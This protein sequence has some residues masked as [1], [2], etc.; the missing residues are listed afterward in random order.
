MTNTERLDLDSA[1]PAKRLAW[2]NSPDIRFSVPPVCTALWT[3]DDWCTYV[4]WTTENNARILA[5]YRP[6]IHYPYED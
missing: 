6:S 1:G 4:D 3:G 5:E 2:K